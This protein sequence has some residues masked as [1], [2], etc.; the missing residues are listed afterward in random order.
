MTLNLRASVVILETGIAGSWAA[1]TL[2]RATA[3]VLAV[4]VIIT[5]FSSRYFHSW[6]PSGWDDPHLQASLSGNLGCRA[7]VQADRVPHSPVRPGQLG[8]GLFIL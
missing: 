2:A 3:D 1:H 5:T 6:Q 8:V 4:A 7:S